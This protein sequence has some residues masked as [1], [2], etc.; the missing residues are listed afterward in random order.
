R[1]P[2]FLQ[3]LNLIGALAILAAYVAN[4]R[5][6]LG[7]ETRLYSLLNL[8]GAILLLWVAIEDLRW[9]FILLEGV[10]AL[11]SIPPLLRTSSPTAS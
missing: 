10:W 8:V 3:I 7:P 2:V 1:A 4:Q 9:G 5:R 11:V 6:W